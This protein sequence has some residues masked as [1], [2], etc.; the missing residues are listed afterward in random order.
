MAQIKISYQEKFRTEATMEGCDQKLYTDVPQENGGRGECLSPTDLLA[1]ALGSCILTVMAM[2]AERFKL[3]FQ[4]VTLTVEKIVQPGPR[5]LQALIVHVRGP[6]SFDEQS[7]K[8]LETAALHCPVHQS[9]HPDLKQ[10]LHFAW[11]RN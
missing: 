6:E 10:E 5:H 11:D 3:P 4:G 8:R 2:A 9:L 7:R 1:A